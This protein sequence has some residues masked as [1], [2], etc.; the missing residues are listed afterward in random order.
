MQPI[1]VVVVVVVVVVV[2]NLDNEDIRTSTK[3]P[4][5]SSRHFNVDKVE[6]CDRRT[7]VIRTRRV[8]K[9]SMPANF[10]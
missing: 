6:R 7:L 3:S 8:R 2:E 9:D 10:D 5:A 4:I 1:R